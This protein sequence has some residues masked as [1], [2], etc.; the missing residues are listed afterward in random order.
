MNN[1]WFTLVLTQNC[2]TLIVFLLFIIAIA[3]LFY[4]NPEQIYYNID[5]LFPLIG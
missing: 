5:L 4:E 2:L 3:P 1:I